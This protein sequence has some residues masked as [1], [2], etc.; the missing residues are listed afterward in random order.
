MPKDQTTPTA[1]TVKHTLTTA[2]LRKNKKSSKAVTAMA[3]PMK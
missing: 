3:A 1:T 2:R